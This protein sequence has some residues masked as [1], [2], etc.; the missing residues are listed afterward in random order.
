MGPLKLTQF[1]ISLILKWWQNLVLVDMHFKTNTMNCDLYFNC[2][3]QNNLSFHCVAIVIK[4]EEDS[5]SN[6]CFD[7]LVMYPQI[8][9]ER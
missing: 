5:E 2:K 8:K 9:H 6:V 7:E 4:T 1:C 3:M